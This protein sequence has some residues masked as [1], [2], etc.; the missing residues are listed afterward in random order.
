[1][2]ASLCPSIRCTCW[3][4]APDA[5]A[6]EAA[7]CRRSCGRRPVSPVRLIAPD[8]PTPPVRAPDH[9]SVGTR[10]HQIARPATGHELDQLGHER[11]RHRNLSRLVVLCRRPHLVAAVLRHR[12]SHEQPAPQLV[13][14]LYSQRDALTEAEPADAESQD[15]QSIVAGLD[16]ERVQGTRLIRPSIA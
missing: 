5:I 8:H 12:R 11:A 15:H 14:S 7:V 4:E 2:A 1:M 16:R 3:T 13:D 6:R 9:I 10:E